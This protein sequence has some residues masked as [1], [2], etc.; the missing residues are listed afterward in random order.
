MSKHVDTREAAPLVYS[1]IPAEQAQRAAEIEQELGEA[2]DSP[3]SSPPQSPAASS[4]S[5]ISPDYSPTRLLPVS[6]STSPPYK[7]AKFAD[8]LLHADSPSSSLVATSTLQAAWDHWRPVFTIIDYI[9]GDEFLSSAEN[10][11]RVFQIL[12]SILVHYYL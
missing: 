2:Q 5:T 12:E 11:D 3:Y 9:Q 8:L 4:L 6:N 10:L 1:P 7:R